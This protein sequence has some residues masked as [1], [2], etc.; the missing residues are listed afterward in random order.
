MTNGIRTNAIGAPAISAPSSGSTEADRSRRIAD[1]KPVRPLAPD[2]AYLAGLAERLHRGLHRRLSTCLPVNMAGKRSTNVQKAAG[3][4]AA[5]WRP[6]RCWSFSV[7]RQMTPA[8]R[9]ARVP[10]RSP[11][12]AV[13][14]LLLADH[15]RCISSGTGGRRLSATAW[16]VSGPGCCSRSRPGSSLVAAFAGRRRCRRRSLARQPAVWRV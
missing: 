6:R 7:V 4:C 15:G 5:G 8:A 14:A 2:G 9:Y 11:Q 13:F 10:V 16:S 1:L 3:V 12:A